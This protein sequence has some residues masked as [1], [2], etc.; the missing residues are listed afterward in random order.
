[1]ACTSHISYTVSSALAAAQDLHCRPCC[2]KLCVRTAT[3]P[4]WGLTTRGWKLGT[5]TY[6]RRSNLL[7]PSTN[8]GL[9]MYLDTTEVPWQHRR[10]AHSVPRWLQFLVV[11]VLPTHSVQPRRHQL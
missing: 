3:Q 5:S 8:K 10:Q 6:S 2:S 1:M 7:P 4:Y 11:A 9:L